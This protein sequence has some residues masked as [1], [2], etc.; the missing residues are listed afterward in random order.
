M[1]NDRSLRE[2]DGPEFDRAVVVNRDGVCTSRLV[3]S[4][5]AMSQGREALLER[6]RFRRPEQGLGANKIHRPVGFPTLSSVCRHRLLPPW[7]LR[8]CLQPEKAHSDRISAED[9]VGI[10]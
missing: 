5:Y 2:G 1:A 10:K 9:I 3:G 7:R 6:E 8:V 4:R